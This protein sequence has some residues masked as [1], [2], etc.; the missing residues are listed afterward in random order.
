METSS[1]VPP[2]RARG[3]YRAQASGRPTLRFRG[4]CADDD[5]HESLFRWRTCASPRA[6]CEA[7]CRDAHCQGRNRLYAHLQDDMRARARMLGARSADGGVAD[8][9]LRGRAVPA[10]GVPRPPQSRTST[11]QLAR[12][13]P[14]DRQACTCGERGGDPHGFERLWSGR[15]ARSAWWPWR[16]SRW[17]PVHDGWALIQRAD[18][19]LL[20]VAWCWRRRIASA[21]AYMHGEHSTRGGQ[22]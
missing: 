17:N 21:S 5:R 14:S 11:R 13:K 2:P 3:G 20:R 15:G 10:Q 4:I 18:G 8:C 16:A 19:A 6:R 1:A 12:A 22:V 7:M 9:T